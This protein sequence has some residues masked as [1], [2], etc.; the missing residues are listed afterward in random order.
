LIC[1]VLEII[2]AVMV[3]LMILI[4]FYHVIMRYFF[5]MAPSWT[6][7]AARQL[8]ICFCFIA[9]MLG[10]KEKIHI[11]LTIFVDHLPRNIVFVIELINKILI[12]A[13]GILMGC[14]SIPYVTQLMKNRLPATNMPVGFQYLIPVVIGILIGLIVFEQI[15]LQIRFGT[16][17]ELKKDGSQ[18]KE[19]V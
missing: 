4:I 14:F 2:G 1:G 15:I 18:P 19:A 11:A 5:N 3:S 9:M 16:D 6:E 12:L 17:E 10:V 13:F 7:E 8:M